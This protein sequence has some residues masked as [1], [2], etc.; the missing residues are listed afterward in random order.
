[1]AGR[2]REWRERFEP[3]DGAEACAILFFPV[4]LLLLT[5]DFG[6][7]GDLER[8]LWH[9]F[10]VAGCGY[11]TRWLVRQAGRLE[12]GNP[13]RRLVRQG[14]AMLVLMMLLGVMTST[15]PTSGVRAGAAGSLA[16]HT[17]SEVP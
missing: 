12:P 1:M 16:Q 5:V 15:R 7:T 9:L 4:A 14:A 8:Y 3:T 2:W 13:A 6:R 11:W 10:W 17:G